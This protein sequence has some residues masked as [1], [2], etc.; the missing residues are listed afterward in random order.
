M[1]VIST[2]PKV[3]QTEETVKLLVANED[4]KGNESLFIMTVEFGELEEMLSELGSDIG[5]SCLI[6]DGKTIELIEL[7]IQH[8]YKFELT[9]YREPSKAYYNGSVIPVTES[10]L[11]EEHPYGFIPVEEYERVEY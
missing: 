2:T 7:F 5:Y 1:I 8:D 3:N 10:L 11:T 4:S 6:K 9:L